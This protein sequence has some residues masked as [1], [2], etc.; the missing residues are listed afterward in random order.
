MNVRPI[1][2]VEDLRAAYCI[3]GRAWEAAY[4]EFLPADLVE[5]VG[6][7]PVEDELRDQ[8]ESVVDDCYLIAETE[9]GDAV[10]YCYV[11]WGENTKEFVGEDAAGLKELYVD[12][13]HWGEG[14]GTELLDAAI[15][16]IPEEFEGLELETLAKNEVGRS[17]YEARGF[18]AVDELVVELGK[19][20]APAVVYRLGL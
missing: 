9:S 7:V 2:S 17:F 3:N 20:E 12:P 16:R 11:R 14:V 13:E 19:Y 4:G 6:T 10:G 15:D 18:E 1:E 8:F 5:R